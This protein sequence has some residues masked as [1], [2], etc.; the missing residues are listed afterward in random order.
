MSRL[1]ST[2][3]MRIITCA[4][5]VCV[6]VAAHAQDFGSNDVDFKLE[7][8][9][10]AAGEGATVT[11][12]SY[13]VQRVA[14]GQ[15]WSY[16]ITHDRNAVQI[17]EVSTE[18]TDAAALISGGFNQTAVVMDEAGN[19]VG[20]IQG[21]VVS[22]LE[23]ITV[24]VTDRFSM[25]RA[26]YVVNADACGGGETDLETTVAYTSD[27]GATPGAPNVEVNWTVA[28]SG[29]VPAVAEPV[30]ITIQCAVVVTPVDIAYKLGSDK[31]AINAD[32]A[33]KAVID[34]IIENTTDGGEAVG[35]Q[36][37]EYAVAVD[38]SALSISEFVAG[39]DAAA[40][41]GGEGPAFSITDPLDSDD[42]GTIDAVIGGGVV[43]F[44]KAQDQV[45]SL[46]V[47]G[48]QKV[49]RLTVQSAA[50]IVEPDPAQ[51]TSLA[52]QTIEGNKKT[53]TIENVLTIGNLSVTPTTEGLDLGL[54]P[55]PDE[56]GAAGA[57]IRGDA[58]DDARIDIS[59]GIWLIQAL[60]YKGGRKAC[61]AAED[62]NGDGT[63]DIADSMYIFNWRLQP[64]AT[65]GNLFPQPG[66]PFPNC[67]VVEGMAEELCPVGSTSCSR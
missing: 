60:F 24:P 29:V 19:S 42:D 31:E 15:G 8:T 47:G 2:L 23:D 20:F 66:A 56:G 57:F 53:S 55:V 58:N 44:S 38:G 52:Y 33:D 18:G 64:G 30:T 51:S 6:A 25:A 40:L 26:T 13:A 12:E 48:P 5:G 11:V 54:T 62:A 27:L 61:A 34:I 21:F 28:G 50:R 67:G 65:A 7:A 46:A 63:T 59:D 39:E 36:A 22:L 10:S 3:S 14:G 49:G 32:Q 37:W 4:L 16:G 45:L 35:A 9:P 1:V 17:Q 41:N 43:D